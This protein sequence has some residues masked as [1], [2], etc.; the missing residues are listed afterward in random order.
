MEAAARGETVT[1]TVQTGFDAET[2]RPIYETQNLDLKP[3]PKI[4][5]VVDEMADL[6]IVAGKAVE[7]SI[8][9][10]AQMARDAGVHLIMATPRPSVDVITGTLQAT[11]QTRIRLQGPSQ[12]A[13][14]ETSRTGKE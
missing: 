4:V 8:Q 7:G 9:R 13:K 2:G 10:L 5:V 12:L 11:F 1:R 3:L 6:M 14:S